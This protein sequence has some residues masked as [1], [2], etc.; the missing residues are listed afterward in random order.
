MASQEELNRQNEI[1]SA[2]ERRVSL[3]RELVDILSRR[4]GIDGQ[5]VITQRDIGNTLADQLKNLKGHNQEKRS[6]RNITNQINDLA[7]KS[8]SIGAE[9]L[10]NEKERNKVL[11]QISDNESN[12]RKL[13]LERA[14]FARKVNKATGDER[15]LYEAIASSLKDQAEEASDINK[16]LRETVALSK[17]ISNNFGVKTFGALS[18]I[19]KKIPG[20]SRFSEPFQQASEAARETASNIE[21]AAKDGGKGLTK[22][23]IIQLGLEKQVGNLTG[24]AAAAKLKG[25]SGFSKGLASTQAGFKA[26]GPMITKALGP[27]TLIVELVKGIMQ[28]DKET[29]ELQKSM[30]LTKTEAVGFRMGLTEAANQ[31]GN[32]NITATKLL[33]SFGDLNKQFGFI[34]NFATDTLVTM[35]KL[36]EVVGVSSESAGNLAAASER[37]GTSF[38]SN[39]KDVLATS[40]ELQ[41]QS[42][43][44]MDLRQILEQTGKV[45]GTVRA[46]LGANPA[47][48]AKAITQAKLF[49]AS[50][51]QV[52]AAGK[53]L[54]DFESS[55]TAELEAE[56][57]LGKNI[58]LE[59]ARAAALAGDQV[60]LAQELQKEA[61]NFSDFTKMNVIQ[62]E[63]LAKAMGM[64]SDQLADILFQQEVQGKSAKELRALG[65]EELAQRVE[66][67][68]LQTKFNATVEKLQA[69]FVDVAS[70]LTPLLSVLGDVFSIVGKIFEFLSPVMGTLTGIAAGAAV[71]G[72][73]GAIIGGVL[74]AAGDI[75]KAVSTA[76]DAIIPS[77]YGD[78]IIKKGKDTIALNN[79]DT[80]VAGT[81]LMSQTSTPTDNTEAKRTNQLLERLLNQPAVF[82]IGTDEFYTATSKYTY[83]IQ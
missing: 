28:A 70:A 22:E 35:T 83:Q 4:V 8:Y 65:K 63:A 60:T 42:G 40:Y 12:I 68:D 2:L 1:N 17:E 20:L 61:G 7:A 66:A 29:T 72:I 79:N 80:V 9:T 76:D 82:K 57:L 46:N 81:N 47:L 49:G 32:I 39:Y 45:T 23:K 33:K 67:Q 16:Q 36:T 55:I 31:S 58:N 44:Q 59:R 15:R 74:G 37:T 73:P 54:L 26:L 69:I 24:A 77:G 52:A 5:N 10:G 13:N 78:T 38:E 19:T 75:T 64:T 21:T 41:R 18:D 71:G 25:M 43:V 34:T 51:E 30:A 14:E 11:K 48:I 27:L 3:E 6:I 53:S 56:L 62:Q 50:L